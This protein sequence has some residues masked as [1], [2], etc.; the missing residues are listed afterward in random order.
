[1]EASDHPVVLRIGSGYRDSIPTTMQSVSQYL[2]YNPAHPS[3]RQEASPYCLRLYR[4]P[5]SEM[6][7]IRAKIARTICSAT[8]K[9]TSDFGWTR[10][11]HDDRIKQLTPIR[12]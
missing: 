10:I 2:V 12:S 7:S 5:P 11:T 4:V 1:M 9:F 6:V 8:C 3:S